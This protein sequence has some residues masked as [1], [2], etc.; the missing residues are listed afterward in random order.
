MGVY[1]Y[2]YVCDPGSTPG[3]QVLAGML[4]NFALVDPVSIWRHGARFM[5]RENPIA[6]FLPLIPG[7]TI[8]S[9]GMVGIQ[10][11]YLHVTLAVDTLTSVASSN[12]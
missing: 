10:T 5:S 2:V 6:L 12:A 3:F 8:N 11:L 4:V 1:V 7:T 9:F